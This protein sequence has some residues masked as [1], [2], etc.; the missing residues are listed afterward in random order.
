MNGPSTLRLRVW[1]TNLGMAADWPLSPENPADA[2]VELRCLPGATAIHVVLSDHDGVHLRAEISAEPEEVISLHVQLS[3]NG[4]PYVRSRERDVLLLPVDARYEPAPPITRGRADAPVDIAI[5]VDGT[6]RGSDPNAASDKQVR[7][8][9]DKPRWEAH[10]DTL[11]GVV[12]ELSR[13]GDTRTVV[14]AFGDQDPVGVAAPDLQP[15]YHLQPDEDEQVL[16]HFTPAKLKERLL[17][18]PATPG[19]DFVDALADALAACTRLRWRPGARKL[20]IITGDSPGLSLLHPLPKGAD[21][22]VRARDV[23]TE[24]MR[25]HREQIEIATIYHAPPLDRRALLPVERELLHEA[26]AQYE[27]LASLPALAFEAG[28]L[29]VASA[30]SC[31]LQNTRAIGRGAALG[32]L[33]TA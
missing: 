20:V 13:G 22:C 2:P 9:D 12:E 18:C 31:L 6:T 23:D 1:D 11:I 4:T 7:L 16:Q 21:V 29:D 33:V 27:R 19:G 26:R 17:A 14:I 30:V 8:L 25:L 24:A 5:I 15:D 3:E 10:A 32:E 28:T